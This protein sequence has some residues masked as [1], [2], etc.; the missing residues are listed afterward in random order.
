[1]A[2]TEQAAVTIELTKAEADAV[3]WFL[4]G[5]D[6]DEV[7]AGTSEL[8]TPKLIVLNPDDYVRAEKNE[9]NFAFKGYEFMDA[10]NYDWEQA[11][12][13]LPGHGLVVKNEAGRDCLQRTL[14]YLDSVV[15]GNHIMRD[16]VKVRRASGCAANKIRSA[17]PEWV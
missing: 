17:F 1:M 9:P 2:T 12:E 13:W 15:D 11:W 7:D 3:S 16:D 4:D 8:G 10:G 6:Y 5:I 14:G